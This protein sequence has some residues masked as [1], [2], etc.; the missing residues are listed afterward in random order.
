MMLFLLAPLAIF[1]SDTFLSS[2]QIS[3]KDKNLSLHGHVSIKHPLGIVTADEAEVSGLTESSFLQALL[4]SNVEF[5]FKEDRLVANELL[6]DS[7]KEEIVATG[8][9]TLYGSKENFSLSCDG[10]TQ[11][12]KASMKLTFTSKVLP[13][14]FS[15]GETLIHA[16][17]AYLTFEN[18]EPHTLVFTEG[19]D[20]S[21]G[22]IKGN[23]GTLVYELKDHSLHGMG[24][25]SFVLESNET[26]NLLDLWKKKPS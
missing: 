1:A 13:I 4:K 26:V 18:D 17:S 11:F 24:K 5:L 2:D 15:K 7:T 16:K 19:V 9:T 22:S 14:S 8:P 3:Y 23:A 12:E 21:N 6:L 20:I 10:E 25:V